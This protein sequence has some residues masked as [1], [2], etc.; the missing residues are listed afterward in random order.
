MYCTALPVWKCW[1]CSSAVP[2]PLP[3]KTIF[4]RLM[5]TWPILLP[6]VPSPTHSYSICFHSNQNKQAFLCSLVTK[7]KFWSIHPAITKP[8][9]L[10]ICKDFSSTVHFYC[11]VFIFHLLLCLYFAYSCLITTQMALNSLSIQ[12][13]FFPLGWQNPCFQCKLNAKKPMDVLI[14]CAHRWA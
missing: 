1:L 7:I 10:S 3:V 12:K 4:D 11:M 8:F 9:S 14:L 5:N 13:S 6:S 2:P